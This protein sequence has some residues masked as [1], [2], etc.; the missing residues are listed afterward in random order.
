MP[1]FCSFH[2]S[3]LAGR[4]MAAAIAAARRWVKER[5]VSLSGGKPQDSLAADSTG[6]SSGSGVAGFFWSNK[7][8]ETKPYN[9]ARMARL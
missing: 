8:S 3:L 2:C 7:C 5:N 6:R 1:L 4:A 9:S